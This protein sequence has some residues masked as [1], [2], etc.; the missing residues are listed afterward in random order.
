MSGIFICVPM[1]SQLWLLNL[2]ILI[3]KLAMNKQFIKT[4]TKVCFSMS[5]SNLALF[6][7]LV[8][9]FHVLKSY[10]Y[11]FAIFSDKSVS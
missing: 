10:L 9:I 8:M 1:W 7:V 5:T 6:W 4:S 3:V 11:N 2:Q